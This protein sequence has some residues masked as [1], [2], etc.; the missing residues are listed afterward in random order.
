MATPNARRKCPCC[1]GTN[2]RHGVIPDSSH[3]AFFAHRLRFKP[4][5]NWV[6][7]HEL[8]AFACTD[9]GHVGLWLYEG[10]LETLR[11]E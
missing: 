11:S 5:G 6:T 3:Q 10:D 9:C 8:Q 7:T 2:L 1:S 4:E